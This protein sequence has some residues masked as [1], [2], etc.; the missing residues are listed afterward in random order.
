MNAN[1]RT[2]E[3]RKFS[4]QAVCFGQGTRREIGCETTDL[5]LEGAFIAGPVE[6]FGPQALVELRLRLEYDG[7]SREHALPARVVRVTDQGAGLEFRGLSI[8]TYSALLGQ[9]YSI[10][11]QDK[12][13]PFAAPAA[14]AGK[15]HKQ[16]H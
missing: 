2:C 14:N 3:R 15:A 7:V 4:S 1:Q 13:P 6:P 12:N 9:L 11:S 8:G 5:S 10:C 16:D